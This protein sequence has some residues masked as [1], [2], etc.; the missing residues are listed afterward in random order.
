MKIRIANASLAIASIGLALLIA[1]CAL[2]LCRFEYPRFHQ[3]DLQTG[4][5]LRPNHEGWWRSE[6]QAWISINRHG[7][8]DREHNKEKPPDTLR[9]AVLGDSFAEAL[10]VPVEKT[11]WAVLE[12]QLNACRPFGR[13]LVEVINFGVSGYGTAQELLTLQSRVWDFAP[14]IV[15]L[16]FYTGNDIQNN[17]KRLE[18]PAPMPFFIHRDGVL[19][20]DDSFRQRT[21][22]QWSVGVPGAV[23]RAAADQL[24]LLQFLRFVSARVAAQPGPGADNIN[25]P[26]PTDMALDLRT[27]L[28]REPDDAD[29]IE[30]W[31]ITEELLAM[32]RSEVAS[33]NARF[34]LATLSTDIQVHPDRSIREAFQRQV[35]TESLFHADQRLRE[36]AARHGI[37]IITLAPTMQRIAEETG[38]FL[39]GF[40]NNAFGHWN[41]NGHRVAGSLLAK[42]LCADVLPGPAP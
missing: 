21:L 22:T 29:W 15:L 38:G 5:A 40:G 31:A 4:W 23:Y 12:Q 13:R 7:Q 26:Q 28:Y 36:V 18:P 16:A 37:E 32:L 2:R 34:I 30:A 25:A 41:E 11:F 8:R 27:Q 39:H 3:P 42:H 9:I 17:S 19:V 33:R 1:E 10:Q 24:R 35:G 6:G 20:L 14:D